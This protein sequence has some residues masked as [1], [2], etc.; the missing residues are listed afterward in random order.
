M[1]I[2]RPH[3]SY[4]ATSHLTFHYALA[5]SKPKGDFA[6]V[7]RGAHAAYDHRRAPPPNGF[8]HP[9]ENPQWLVAFIHS[10]FRV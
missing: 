3:T 5:Q 7:G 6:T 10:G 8:P 2:T 4:I 1:R 9:Y